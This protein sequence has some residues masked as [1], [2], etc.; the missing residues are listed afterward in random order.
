MASP[1]KITYRGPALAFQGASFSVNELGVATTT[2]RYEGLTDALRSFAGTFPPGNK[3]DFQNG[4]PTSKLQVQV[5][6]LVGIPAESPIDK[7]ENDS[8][9]IEV[10]LA[11]SYLAQSMSQNGRRALSAY[12]QMT[13]DERKDF[14]YAD[15]NVDI[16][17]DDGQTLTDLIYE[18][19]RGVEAVIEKYLILKRTRTMSAGFATEFKLELKQTVYSTVALIASEDIPATVAKTLPTSPYPPPAN[20]NWA[21]RPRLEN[22]S[23]IG[24]GLVEEQSDWVF[25]PHSSILFTYVE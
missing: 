19:D 16:A 22:R 23:Y 24:R 7:W 11:N 25:G 4:G 5:G 15:Y 21:W 3:V 1:A 13:P 14:S 10:D 18:V 20:T 6:Y 9:E 17:G 2:L 12:R 8:E